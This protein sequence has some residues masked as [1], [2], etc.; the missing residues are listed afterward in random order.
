M[1]RNSGEKGFRST[2]FGMNAKWA[3]YSDVW[4][5]KVDRVGPIQ[6][7]DN[8]VINK[9][10]TIDRDSHRGEILMSSI[11][12]IQVGNRIEKD[13]SVT[14]APYMLLGTRGGMARVRPKVGL[15]KLVDIS[16]KK[17]R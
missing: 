8:A 5:Y 11:Q 17:Y 15:T 14:I 13:K 10:V 4:I 6:R 9:E 2:G 12:S 16:L 7:I 3:D 1:V